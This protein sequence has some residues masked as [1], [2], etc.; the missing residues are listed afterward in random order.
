MPLHTCDVL[1]MHS[2]PSRAGFLYLAV[3]VQRAE[4]QGAP[5][6]LGDEECIEVTN[7]DGVR[8][9]QCALPPDE[10]D[11]KVP[12]TEQTTTTICSKGIQEVAE[13][14]VANCK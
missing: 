5:P 13:A 6:Q 7:L 12:W 11:I 9:L 3:Y 4:P 1:L 14:R 2:S 10:E 8:L